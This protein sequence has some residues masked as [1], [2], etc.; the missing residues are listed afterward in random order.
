M[1]AARRKE[2]EKLLLIEKVRIKSDPD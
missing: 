2:E 1:T